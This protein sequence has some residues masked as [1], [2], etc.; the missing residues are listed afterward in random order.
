MPAGLR[1]AALQP[2]ISIT[3]DRLGA[4]DHGQPT[5]GLRGRSLVEVDDG[6][7]RLLE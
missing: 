4:L 2:S 3:L 7:G 6:W 1:I 5:G